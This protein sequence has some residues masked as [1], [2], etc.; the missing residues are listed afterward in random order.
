MIT[1]QNYREVLR[2][3]HPRPVV[4]VVTISGSGLVNGCTVSWITPVNIDPPT[5]AFSLSPKRYT[6]K[7][8]RESNEATINIVGIEDLEKA[9]YVG[10]VSGRD[11]ADKLVKAGFTLTS[12]VK[13]KPPTIKE[14]LGVLE[15]RVV[16]EMEFT[17]HNLIICEVIHARVREELFADG[18]WT[19]EARILLH[20]G[21]NKYTSTSKHVRAEG[22]D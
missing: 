9:H 18:A 8:L 13:V 4:I 3:L 14:A 15:C 10:T 21:G 16:G 19:E 1:V 7:L 17:D 2:L 11:V 6:Y 22:G 20:V 5:I 12:S